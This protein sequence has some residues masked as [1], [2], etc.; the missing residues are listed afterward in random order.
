MDS[1]FGCFAST[2]PGLPA[3][4]HHPAVP[5]SGIDRRMRRIEPAAREPRERFDAVGKR[6][7]AL[8]YERG[9]G[10]ARRALSRWPRHSHGAQ[11]RNDMTL[12][13]HLSGPEPGGQA[14]SWWHCRRVAVRRSAGLLG[15]SRKFPCQERTIAPPS[16]TEQTNSG[17]RSTGA[18][19][20]SDQGAPGVDP[21][22]GG[23]GA[24]PQ[25][26]RV[27]GRSGRRC[28]TDRRGHGILANARVPIRAR[29][30]AN[31]HSPQP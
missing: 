2:R 24:F 19:R 10:L 5:G 15:R 4:R 14:S 20:H 22:V 13:L 29:A 31:R 28:R 12:R 23:A 3:R 17:V 9:Y 1:L 16:T 26:P 27:R 7:R 18:R 8:P 25:P 21:S 11:L 6:Y 30:D